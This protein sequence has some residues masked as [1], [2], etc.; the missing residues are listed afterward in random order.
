MYAKLTEEV[1]KDIAEGYSE[2]FGSKVT[3]NIL[4]NVIPEDDKE[5]MKEV[6]I[7][8][9]E[10]KEFDL[11]GALD[12]YD[13]TFPNYTPS[14][15][16]W[17]FFDLMRLVQGE[18]F[19]FNTPIAHYFMAD[20]LLGSITTSDVFP[21]SPEIN[22]QIDVDPN[23]LGFMASR[24]LAKSTIGIS[25]FAVYSAIKGE[26]PNGIGKVY[27]YLL[28]AASSKGGARVN[29][30]AVRAMCEE[31]KFLNDYFEDMRFT[32]TESEF[33]RKGDGPRK[34]RSFLIRYQGINTGVRGS[35]Y[36]ERRP[37]CH[38]RGTIVT[39]EYGTYPVEDHPGLKSEGHFEYCTIVKL[40]GLPNTEIVSND[41][42][43]WAKP[44]ARG[45]CIQDTET[46]IKLA[47][48]SEAIPRW[49]SASKLNNDYWVGSPIDKEIV[50]VPAIPHRIPVACANRGTDGRIIGG[51]VYS[52][53]LRIH[54]H[55]LDTEWW[56]AYGLWLGD[57]TLGT[58]S[59][60]TN[61]NNRAIVVWS[62]AY[63]EECTVGTKLKG[64][65]ERL[66]KKYSIHN[67]DGC[68]NLRINDTALAN[69]MRT[70]KTGNS[71]KV[72]PEWVL[73]L[74]TEKQKQL[75]LGYI[76]ADGFIDM[77]RNRQVRINSVNYKILQQLQ[78]ICS[79]L[80]LPS[81]IRNTKQA[82][83][84]TWFNGITCKHNQQWEIRLKDN[85]SD[86]L[87]ITGITN[88]SNYFPQVHIANGMLWRQVKSIEKTSVKHELIPI[89]CNNPELANSIG[90]RHAYTTE[91]GISKN[92]ILFDDAILNTA[93]AYSKI[94]SE[95]LDEI[96]HSDST[97]ALKGGGKGRVILY[98][99][100]FHYGDVNTKAI[101]QGAF[102]P[103]VVPMAKAFDAEQV[104]KVEDIHSSWEA[105]H[106][107]HSIVQLIRSAKKA[108]KLRLFMQERMLRLTSGADRLIPDNCIQWCDIK[109]I[110]KNIHAYNIYIT[111]DYTTTSGEKS[112]FSGIAT[113]AL[114][115]ND[116]LFLLNLTLR[117]RNMDAQYMETLNEAAKWRRMGKH[118]EIGV[119]VDGNQSAHI[120]SLEKEMMKR[121]DW[122]TFAKQKGVESDR[123]GILSKA[124]GVRKHERFRIA[125]Q[126]F[127][128]GKIWFPEHLKE[129]PDMQ[130]FV[131]QIKGAT[132]E[133][134][135]RADDGPD[136]IT[137]I[138]VSMQTITPSY[139]APTPET[140]DS[141]D[142]WGNLPGI[143]GMIQQ[144]EEAVAG[145]TVF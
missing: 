121:G 79:R 27:F 23:R 113:W 37:D 77:S 42:K 95:N 76:A 58:T 134:F 138:V 104:V 59:T 78:V 24:G 120:F 92:C 123:K 35:R 38:V 48:Y 129:T 125:S 114:S 12:T 94:M 119:E 64:I 46:G 69:W 70:Q 130:E 140:D 116:D 33:V 109:P 132:H 93:A 14:K 16:A 7:E 66:G 71:C 44:C 43:Y 86:I 127:L 84:Q 13:P 30:L 90:E 85:V 105:M 11:D 36:G 133:T 26:L 40:S 65:L 41:H 124:T 101:L 72:M 4:N 91:F 34:N 142:E 10:D 55:M 17:E 102:T 61:A 18:D 67:A 137:M 80:G 75:L 108:R 21:Y 53:V 6:L 98:F 73:K 60:A 111:T 9:M 100:P 88:G 39:T 106:P 89:Q 1:K 68:Y 31:S 5:Y 128:N 144:E 82:G 45:R 20:M 74:D 107:R 52:D 28:L 112:D 19:E 145:S 141:I 62:V 96:I 50:P 32:E 63:T 22:A 81:H 99:T 117:K 8:L 110:I 115:S 103:V 136:L 47:R 57:G 2:S 54:E 87:G 118:V 122:F 56:W 139:D 29:A 83:T 135:T 51:A 131:A 15:Y 126:A 49:V 25:F 3:E 97:N 143:W